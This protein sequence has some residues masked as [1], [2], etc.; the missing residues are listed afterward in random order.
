MFKRPIN[1]VMKK[2][3]KMQY[4]QLVNAENISSL[5]GS[6]IK[7]TFK[8]EEPDKKDLYLHNVI[9]EWWENSKK[10]EDEFDKLKKIIKR[11][12][13]SLNQVEK[14]NL[15][16]IEER[17]F[18][19][20]RHIKVLEVS[21]NLLPKEQVGV[22]FVNSTIYKKEKTLSTLASGDLLLTNRRIIITGEEIIAVYWSAI[23]NIKY[24]SY[25]FEFAHK[26]ETFVIRIHDQD[27]LNNT[28]KNFIKKRV[29]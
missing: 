1:P 8:D 5:K 24:G 11:A 15:F 7:K 19:I 28:I 18:S 2:L 14:H 13:I 22:K 25:G 6:F 12:K 27:T 9:N 16:L 21:A 20:T 29:K 26:E 23:K 17:I 3:L 10:S 4:G